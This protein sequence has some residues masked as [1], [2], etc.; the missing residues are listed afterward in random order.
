MGVLQLPKKYSNDFSVAGRQPLGDVEVD[1]SNPLSR[2]LIAVLLP[3]NGQ[4]FNLVAKGGLLNA[5][6]F[7]TSAAIGISPRLGRAGILDG[8]AFFLDQW[9]PSLNFSLL[10]KLKRRTSGERNRII[11]GEDGTNNGILN[12]RINSGNDF[13]CALNSGVGGLFG[14]S[15][16]TI[17]SG[18]IKTVGITHDDPNTTLQLYVDGEADA[19]G[20]T[21]ST[22]FSSLTSFVG[23]GGVQSSTQTLGGNPMTGD[24][25]YFFIWDDRTL[26]VQEVR[27]LSADPYQI[28]KPKNDPVY[29]VPTVA[30][31]VTVNVPVG[32]LTLTGQAPVAVLGPLTIDIPAGAMSLTGFAPDA[33][34]SVVAAVPVGSLSL[35]G[36]A[37]F[38][39]I[40]VTIP[41]GSL[42]LTGFAPTANVG[43]P[44][45]VDVPTGTLSLSGFAPS[46]I[47][48]DNIIVDIP[49]GSMSLTGQV[50]VLAFGPLSVD[51]PAGSLSLTGF[52]PLI[53][54]GGAIWT[55]QPDEVTTWTAQADISTVWT[56][57]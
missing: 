16:A 50:P 1:W 41:V 5:Y 38:A 39:Q 29:F 19:T 37:P 7:D 20:V 44:V 46:A 56:V 26:S 43:E 35:T 36:F 24:F 13:F 31:G 14:S 25:E 33:D 23:I 3:R 32:T 47:L 45:T 30:A 9:T 8:S 53:I 54:E 11:T 49:A 15:T 21:T 48:T 55:T 17:G 34:I 4:M 12:F 40:T 18:E 27:K 6:P 2:G 42:L 57:Q 28:L 51:V 22:N 10:T 52:A